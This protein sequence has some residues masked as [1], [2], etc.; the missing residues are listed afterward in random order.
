MKN[1]I[2]KLIL[3][4]ITILSLGLLVACSPEANSTNTQTPTTTQN[5]E[6][7]SQTS[8]STQTQTTQNNETLTTN[9]QTTQVENLSTSIDWSSL[10]TN[11]IT[12]SNAL[13]NITEGGTYVLTGK[14]EQGVKVN[15]DANVRII[16][17]GVE[18][19]SPDNAAIYVE[20]AGL[21][22]I[23][24]QENTTNIIKDSQTHT[25][26]DIEGVI[27]AKSDLYITGSG[28]LEVQANFQDGI[29]SSDNLF[30]ESGKITVK[31]VDD[32]IRGKDSVTVIGGDINI[33]A[34]GDGIKSNNDTDLDKGNLYIKGG[35][36]NIYSGDDA[37]KAEQSVV[38]DGG[39]INI[40]Q[41]V[42]SIEGTNVTINGG[43]IKTYATDD[44]V[45][46]ASDVTGADIFIRITGGEITVE[47]GS[48]DTDAFDA[49]G[50]IYISGGTIYAIGQMSRFDFDGTVEFTGGTVYENGQQVTEIVS[51]GPGG[52]VR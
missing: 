18:I 19:S 40:P 52:R 31:A 16:L 36:I 25:D 35:N 13:L 28:S 47:A 42:E 43:Q 15:T 8:D 20:N 44:G 32:G 23:N 9:S 39:N 33:E 24:L 34:T 51:H 45:N 11:N 1:E 12:L 26:A 30:I 7:T 50:N 4:G 22:E 29:V 49:N 3:T 37:I 5:A 41:S 27:H 38:I 14:T 48:G 2:K 46:A 21:V 17:Q 6:S 10:P